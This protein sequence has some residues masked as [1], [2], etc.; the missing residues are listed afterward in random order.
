M[1]KNEEQIIKKFQKEVSSELDKLGKCKSKQ[2]RTEKLV[3]LYH[4]S[5]ILENYEQLEPTLQK[6][7]YDRQLKDKWKGE[8]R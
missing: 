6:F 8:E 5:L 1:T 2:E 3:T 4:L 7:F